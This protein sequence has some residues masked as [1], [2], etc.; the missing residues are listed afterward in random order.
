MLVLMIIILSSIHLAKNRSKTFDIENYRPKQIKEDY[1]HAVCFWWMSRIFA[2][3]YLYLIYIA[4]HGQSY[5]I[6][7]GFV[8]IMT[9]FFIYL[10]LTSIAFWN[11]D[12][13]YPRFGESFRYDFRR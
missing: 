5:S 9:L 3:P 10:F 12:V 2:I 13:D 1:E 4:F 7:V 6:F 8:F 11:A